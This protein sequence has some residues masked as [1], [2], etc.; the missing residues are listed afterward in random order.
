VK[1]KKS[2]DWGI[3]IAKLNLQQKI[4]FT[5]YHLPF[6]RWYTRDH[7]VL[8]R[9]ANKDGKLAVP[10]IHELVRQQLKAHTQKERLLQTGGR[11]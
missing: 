10:S 3:N 11:D 4:P 1:A 9:Y 5:I 6:A 7:F 2:W 8:S